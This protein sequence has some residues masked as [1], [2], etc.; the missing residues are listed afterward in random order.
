MKSEMVSGGIL[1]RCFSML[2][3]CFLPM[4]SFGEEYVPT[5]DEARAFSEQ[6]RSLQRVVPKDDPD[7][8]TDDTRA[9]WL[10]GDGWRSANID[11]SDAQITEDVGRSIRESDS[12]IVQEMVDAV[13]DI[14]M[15]D[16]SLNTDVARIAVT[17][18]AYDRQRAQTLRSQYANYKTLVSGDAL[19]KVEA[20][21]TSQFARG[22]KTT[23]DT[24]DL[25]LIP[26]PVLGYALKQRCTGKA[27][28]TTN[29]GP[30]MEKSQ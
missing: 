2:L 17:I 24:M 21:A 30:N 22:S 18:D 23:M 28:E 27:S 25:N 15:A 10:T 12:S 26:G 20:E 1:R 9:L 8:L 14:V 19:Q 6:M 4:A 13:C 11:E 29:P 7:F 16:S 3:I 5:L